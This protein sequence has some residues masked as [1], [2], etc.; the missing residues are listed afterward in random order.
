MTDEWK[1]LGRKRLCPNCATNPNFLARLRK[2][3]KTAVRIVDISVESR[4]EYLRDTS[5]ERCLS[6]N[7]FRECVNVINCNRGVGVIN[8]AFEPSFDP[9]YVVHELQ[10]PRLNE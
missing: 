1:G 2:I 9:K 5:Q 10:F 3:T 7:L 4:T 8:Q 6:V